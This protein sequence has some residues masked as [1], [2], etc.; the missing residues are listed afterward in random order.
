MHGRS[1]EVQAEEVLAEASEQPEW[2]PFQLLSVPRQSCH[3]EM[4]QKQ[5]VFPDLGEE[6]AQSW[7][8]H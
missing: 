7:L 8:L 3:R 4:L 5:E 6:L 1:Q 2:Q